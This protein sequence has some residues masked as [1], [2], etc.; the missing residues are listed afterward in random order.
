MSYQEIEG[1]GARGGEQRRRKK[2]QSLSA[3]CRWRGR[4]GRVLVFWQHWLHSQIQTLIT[5][6]GLESIG[7]YVRLGKIHCRQFAISEGE[8]IPDGSI[9]HHYL[10]VLFLGVPVTVSAI[11]LV[12]SIYRHCCIV[13]STVDV[14]RIV[15]KIGTKLPGRCLPP[16]VV[17]L[18]GA[19][20]GGACAGVQG[21]WALLY[22][23]RGQEAEV[24]GRVRMRS[25]THAEQLLDLGRQQRP[26]PGGDQRG[27]GGV[28]HRGVV[29]GP[30]VHNPL[31]LESFRRLEECLE[32]VVRNRHGPIVHV[33]HQS[34]KNLMWRLS[35]KI[36]Y[37]SATDIPQALCHWV[38][39]PGGGKDCP[40][41]SS[42][43]RDYRRIKSLCDPTIKYLSWAIPKL[44][45]HFHWPPCLLVFHF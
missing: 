22:G 37:S 18:R 34:I 5:L 33:G 45:V 23:G 26:G 30:R 43:S 20:R 40:S 32:L 19:G 14:R 11:F 31:D 13:L 42:W 15:E 44:T 17:V 38:L 36:I 1:G 8:G 3:W 35:C 28:R 39:G 10:V 29:T 27:H 25:V 41:R 12:R 24:P 9:G 7:S 2:T 21:G 16:L 6:L 4:H